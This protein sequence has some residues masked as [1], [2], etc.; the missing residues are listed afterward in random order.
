M[1]GL[2]TCQHGD[3]SRSV[4]TAVLAS[5]SLEL[6]TRRV[7]AELEGPEA[8]LND[9]RVKVYSTTDSPEYK[10]MIEL[11]G[12]KNVGSISSKTSF[13]L[14]GEN[15]GPSKLEKA[16]KLGIQMMSEDDF[17]NLIE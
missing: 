9:E 12:G 4:N 11:H 3:T 5:D 6:I 16:K 17:L 10:Q 1:V 14:C 13:I 8:A 7:I 15:M 2:I